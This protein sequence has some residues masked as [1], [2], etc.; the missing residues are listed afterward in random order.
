MNNT[1]SFLLSI[2]FFS[3]ISA[4][5]LETPNTLIDFESPEKGLLVPRIDS[6]VR[7]AMIPTIDKKGL[8]GDRYIGFIPILT[9]AIQEQQE[10][11]QIQQRQID[12][13]INQ[14]K[15]IKHMKNKD[16]NN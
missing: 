13:M 1:L 9:K 3:T 16:A 6:S 14:I 8:L 4:Q 7:N 11:I 12:E 2:F 10:I 15:A 5:T